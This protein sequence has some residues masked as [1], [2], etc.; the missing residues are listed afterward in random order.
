MTNVGCPY[1]CLSL[2]IFVFDA[3]VVGNIT[4]IGTNDGA[5]YGGCMAALDEDLAS[6]ALDCP[7]DWVTFSCTGIYTSK[8]AAYRMFDSAQLAFG[9]NKKVEIGV[10]DLRKHDGY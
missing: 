3:V 5:Q 7:D 4:K 9:L 8:D 2:L 6:Y 1:L 10:D